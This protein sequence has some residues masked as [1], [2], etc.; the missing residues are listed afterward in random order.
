MLSKSI[1]CSRKILFCIFLARKHD[2]HAHQ[3][4]PFEHFG[5]GTTTPPHTNYGNSVE[6]EFFGIF[7][8]A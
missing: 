5:G 7:G 2:K 3:N 4:F 1:I 8:G 6:M